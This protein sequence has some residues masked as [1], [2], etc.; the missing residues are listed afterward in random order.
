MRGGIPDTGFARQLQDHSFRGKQRQ[1]DLL[2]EVA[3]YP[4][5]NEMWEN[6]IPRF[7]QI[8]T[9]A[10]V[11]AS[12]S[13]TLHTPG[14]FR[15]W[16]RMASEQKWL[17]VHNSQEWPDYYDEA[18]REDLRRFFDHY[19]IGADN[20]WEHT[21]RVRYALLDLCGGDQTQLP[22]DQF[23]PGDV[24]QTKYYLDGAS[25]TLR[26][27]PPAA[28]DTAAYDTQGAANLVSFLLGFDEETIVVGYPKARLWVE[29]RDA[30]DM[31]LF[32]FLQKLDAQGTPLQEFT[33]PNQSARIH[34]VTEH[35]A[36]ILRYKGSEGRLRV[37]LREL[38]PAHSTDEIP[39]HRFDR[40]AKLSPGEVVEEKIELMP[41]GLV[42]RPGERLRLV[43]SGRNLFGGWMP[44][45]REYAPANRGQHV[46]HTGGAR[47][48]Y[49]QL[50]IT[51]R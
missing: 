19:L 31:D 34:D 11:V 47:L 26:T 15:A 10:Y 17:R 22:A 13:N 18:N 25:R 42:L 24:A 36:T 37:S 20:G 39:A 51:H 7:D 38:D 30:D 14:A 16:R 21:P 28:A 2:A 46:F 27:A 4:L 3:R 9:P 35:G 45:L 12:Y 8:T 32:V 33:V 48:S 49:L 41:V 6:K 23:P 44:G 40:V 5:V 50:P 1:E 29:A 43:I